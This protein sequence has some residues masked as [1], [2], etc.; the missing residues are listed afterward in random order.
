MNDTFHNNIYNTFNTTYGTQRTEIS[1]NLPAIQCQYN[2][3]STVHILCLQKKE[4]R[5]YQM[6]NYR[7][8]HH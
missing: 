3:Y 8:L 6:N 4:N 7:Y 5:T 2:G 1:L